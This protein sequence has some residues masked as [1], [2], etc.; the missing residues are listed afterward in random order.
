MYDFHSEN[1][2]WKFLGNYRTR[3]IITGSWFET[4]PNYKE[5]KIEEY[6][7]LVKKFSVTLTALQYER[8]WKMGLKYT[9]RR[10]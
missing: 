4:S 1:E 7:F 10:L 8:Q 6:P 9:N 5:P 3:A 2:F